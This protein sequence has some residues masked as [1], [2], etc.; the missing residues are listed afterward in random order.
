M[1]SPFVKK[2]RYRLIKLHV[3]LRNC[4]FLGRLDQLGYSNFTTPFGTQK[5]SLLTVHQKKKKIKYICFA[6]L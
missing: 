4:K 6:G 1:T 3:L 2:N 5:K